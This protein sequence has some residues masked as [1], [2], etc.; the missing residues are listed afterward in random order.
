M[1][2]NPLAAGLPS[3]PMTDADG[4]VTAAWRGFFMA[5]QNRTGGAQGASSGDM[6][7]QL[8]A[9]TNARIQGDQALGSAQQA[10]AAALQTALANETAARVAA[11]QDIA[12]RSADNQAAL[13]AET[14][15]RIAGDA[16]LVPKADLRAEWMALDL[17]VLP[18]VDPGMGQPWLD[19]NHIAVGSP[20]AS[21]MTV[22]DGTGHWALE[23]GA[24]NWNYG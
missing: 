13:A 16:L 15:A 14:A 19:G 6:A 23:T 20:P 21:I 10:S 18:L 22:E 24:G 2:I 7:A 8:A 3:T 5:L 17:S 9:E 12:G 11:D 1:A 4:N